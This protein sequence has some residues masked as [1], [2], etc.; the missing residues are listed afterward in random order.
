MKEILI[1]QE[2]LH[3]VASDVIDEFINSMKKAADD[4]GESYG[5]LMEIADRLSLILAMGLLEA[6]LFSKG[7][8]DDE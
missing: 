2:K 6:K 5:E 1:S 3:K 8:E 7:G 4:R